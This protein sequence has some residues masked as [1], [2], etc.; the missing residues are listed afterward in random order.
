MDAVNAQIK[1]LLFYTC[2]VFVLACTF[3]IFPWHKMQN[4]LVFWMA[5]AICS[6]TTIG[7]YSPSLQWHQDQ[8]DLKETRDQDEGE[9]AKTPDGMPEKTRR[10]GN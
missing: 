7:V 9:R 2:L 4:L 5:L 1:F 8:G 6:L 10:E 3:L